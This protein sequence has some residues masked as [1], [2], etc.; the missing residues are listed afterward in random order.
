M[1][2]FSLRVAVYSIAAAVVMRLVPGLRLVPVSGLPE[3]AA[4]LSAY[5]VIG[6]IFGVLHSFIR[7]LILVLA[8]RLYI[9]SMGLLA[10]ATDVF[11]FLLLSYLAPATWEVGVS[12]LL[13]A[14]IGAVLMGLIV[15]ALDAL[16]GFDAPRAAE[17]RKAPFYWR[18]LGML[19]TG[20]RNRL[21]ES[22][23]TQQMIR[24]IESYIIEIIISLSPLR[25][26]RRAMQRLIYRR[27][28]RL[29][30]DNPAVMLRLMLQELGPTFVK[31][32]QLAASRIEILPADWQ[33]ELAR[34][35][36][37][38]Q[39]FPLVEVE[40]AFQDAWGKSPSAI[41]ASFDP[42]P[43]AAASTAQV[44]A[45]TLHNGDAVVVKV[46]RPNIA[47][48]VKGDLNVMQ[49][50]INMAE[51]RMTFFRQFGLSDLF[52]EF[53]EN[54]LVELDYGNE[55]YHAR[56]LQQ[57]MHKYA[58]VQIPKVF[59]AQSTSGILTL[60]RVE[61][62]KISDVAALDAA[63]VNREE[64][65]Q[66]FFR[67]L[68][69]QLLF[70]GFFHADLHPGNVWVNL[71]SQRIIFLDMGMMGQLTLSDRILLGELIW[72]LQ[73]RDAH[74]TV[75]VLVDLCKPAPRRD[76]I[77]LERDV[78]RLIHRHLVFE[79]STASM[80]TV[81]S[82][83]VGM[84]LQYGLQLRREFTLAFKAIGQGESI[85]RILMGDKP[86]D[87]II[88][89][90]F[91]TLKDMLLNQLEPQ[92]MISLAGK[93]LAREAIHRLPALL[94][95]TSALLDDFQHGQSA[96][97]INAGS[98]DQ[99]MNRL[100]AGLAQDIRRVVLSVSLAGLL[101]GCT[102]ILLVPNWENINEP[103]AQAI[104]N[105]AVLGF[106]FSAPAIVILVLSTLWQS[107]R[108]PRER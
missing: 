82:E 88:N 40:Q 58:C 95:A 86:P 59:G 49:D 107:L 5:I 28:V 89:I 30:E 12:R 100:Q 103:Y 67:A 97:Q 70:D 69:Q 18:W 77:S 13:S 78:D 1:I 56:R 31:F 51:Q 52:N 74:A 65:A 8:G 26:F 23:R 87:F 37:D 3:P 79:E 24:I 42:Q 22:L 6:L 83:L 25:G 44:H 80:T 39:P 54:L 7:P 34:L 96:V 76:A 75:Q 47:V 43:M 29:T 72:A 101:L 108:R 62:V 53:A 20:R 9:W 45:A 48:T 64:T 93:S 19:P 14:I 61:G 60:E 55:A 85:M 4:T 90:A 99:R 10:L 68:L 11:I 16:F 21:I 46:R 106:A 32:G 94:S 38:V 71:Q 57:N 63:G 17:V 91:T 92:Q 36:D 73:D 50:V 15:L 66:Q 35:Q 27:N 102:L 104:R 33:R 81:I 2:Y 98:I 41:F 84:L 105:A